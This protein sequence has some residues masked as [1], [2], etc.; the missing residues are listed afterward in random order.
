MKLH[1]D[2]KL[3]SDTL[4]AASQHLAI[5]LEFAEKDVAKCFSEL[6]NKIR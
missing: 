2:I 5:K 4:R 3:F 6:I 1:H